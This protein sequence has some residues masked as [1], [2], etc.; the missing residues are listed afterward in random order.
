MKKSKTILLN[1]LL[2]ILYIVFLPSCDL[3]K[4]RPDLMTL[5]LRNSTDSTITLEVYPKEEYLHRYDSGKIHPYLYYAYIEH[6]VPAFETVWVLGKGTGGTRAF[7]V[8]TRL[9]DSPVLLMNEVFD[10]VIM[11][12]HEFN[13]IKLKFTPDTAVNYSCDMFSDENVWI[14]GEAFDVHDTL[15]VGEPAIRYDFFI[16]K[17]EIIFE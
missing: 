11:Y 2:I 8:T 1:V 5:Y 6:H 13:D 3:L 15:E 16:S 12:V 4:H 7:I 10:S 17:S 14:Y 9:E